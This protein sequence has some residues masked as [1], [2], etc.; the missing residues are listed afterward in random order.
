MKTK[1]RGFTLVEMV[2]AVVILAILVS[3]VVVTV[4]NSR[5]RALNTRVAADMEMI[6][7]AKHLW[8]VDNNGAVFPSDEGAQFAAIQK[9]LPQHRS[10]TSLTDLQPPGVTYHI[11]AL[12]TPPSHTP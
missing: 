2:G 8:V 7:A 11:N 6:A 10:Y 5:E 4:G 12:G 3:V 9:Y 1:K